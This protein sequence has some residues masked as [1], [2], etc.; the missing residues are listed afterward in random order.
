M[1][2]L[3]DAA[4]LVEPWVYDPWLMAYIYLLALYRTFVPYDENNN[5]RKFTTGTIFV[6]WAIVYLG[7]AFGYADV[8]SQAIIGLTAAVYS[9][10][11]VQWGIERTN[12]PID[13]S[14]TGNG[15]PAD[16]QDQDQ[17]QDRDR[18]DD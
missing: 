6:V 10:I 17:D 15:D 14:I 8:S 3:D 18:H 5:F 2:L 9:V 13:I 12:L 11:G 7:D 1:S 16:D 4:A